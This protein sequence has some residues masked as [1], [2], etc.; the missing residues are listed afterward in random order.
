MS[1][2]TFVCLYAGNAFDLDICSGVF[3][4]FTSALYIQLVNQDKK[5]STTSSTPGGS[6]LLGYTALS[7]VGRY[8]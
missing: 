6:S 4:A 5:V 8:K 1:N 2:M 7:K 3:S